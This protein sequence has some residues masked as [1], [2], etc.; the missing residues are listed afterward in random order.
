MSVYVDDAAWRYLGMRMCHMVADTHEELIEMARKIDIR[1]RWIQAEGT[2]KEHFD[3]SHTK[4]T[5]AVKEG[6]IRITSR[7][8]VQRTKRQSDE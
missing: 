2:P 1:E 6:A 7:E 4:R 8:L 3:I 5:L